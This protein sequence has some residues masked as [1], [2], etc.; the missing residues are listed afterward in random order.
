MTTY[1]HYLIDKLVLETKKLHFVHEFQPKPQTTP[2]GITNSGNTDKSSAAAGP[3][4]LLYPYGDAFDARLV[5]A[6]QIHIDRIRSVVL[7]VDAG[8][9]DI[10]SLDLRLRSASA[11]LRLHTADSSI[12]EGQQ[13]ALDTTQA[14][15]IRANAVVPRTKFKIKIPYS[16]ENNLSDVSIRLEA[17]YNTAQGEF[18]FLNTSVIPI[19]LP[20]DVDVQDIF[21]AQALFSKFAIRTTNVIPLQIVNVQLE[22]SAAFTVRPLPCPSNMTVFERQP[23]NLT[24]KVL[25]KEAANGTDIAKKDAAIAL[26]VD[27][28]CMDEVILDCMAIALDS[29]ISESAYS[30]LR[31]L[32]VP[33][34]SNKARSHALAL[35]LEGAVLLGEVSVP[36]YEDVGWDGMINSL[37]AEKREGLAEW[38]QEW[39]KVY[40]HE[41]CTL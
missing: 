31:R 4:L 32:L 15:T 1:G 38:L 25:K 10:R 41:T 35:Q 13:I 20:L 33:I 14:G 8:W 36:S 19:E 16:M 5:L 34:L 11:G 17:Q 23:A 26:T 28:H 7:E 12:S 30:G 27:Y 39:H 37:S 18:V 24:Y 40:T 3:S 9:N 22:D 21:K 2:L 29:G 6:R